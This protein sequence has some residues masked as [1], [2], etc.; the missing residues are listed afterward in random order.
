ML[1]QK[2]LDRW[3]QDFRDWNAVSRWVICP[4]VGPMYVPGTAKGYV[5]S[6]KHGQASES[7]LNKLQNS[8]I[9]GIEISEKSNQIMKMLFQSHLWAHGTIF[10][11]SSL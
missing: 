11:L 6:W 1:L 3:G 10:H 4:A 5:N 9:F 8:L 2:R 7:A